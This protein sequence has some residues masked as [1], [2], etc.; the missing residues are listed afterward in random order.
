MH[1]GL[2]RRMRQLEKRTGADERVVPVTLPDG[3][4]ARLPRAFGEYLVR[5][6]QEC[7][8]AGGYFNYTDQR[9]VEY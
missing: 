6:E 4:V 9:W 1:S 8:A 7:R 5:M 2:R 3:Q